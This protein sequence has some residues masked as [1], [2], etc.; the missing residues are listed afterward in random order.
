MNIT[1]PL[2]GEKI[3]QSAECADFRAAGF[4][5]REPRDEVSRSRRI[6]AVENA[7]KIGPNTGQKRSK[8]AQN[9]GFG[10]LNQGL[11]ANFCQIWSILHVIARYLAQKPG[12][13]RHS[14]VE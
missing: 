3:P 4:A 13:T 10:T 7:F 6:S 5:G 2:N 9:A 11:S 8:T 14:S 12:A 1:P